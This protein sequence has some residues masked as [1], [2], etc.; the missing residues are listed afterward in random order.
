MVNGLI[1]KIIKISMSIVSVMVVLINLFPGTLLSIFGQD[2]EFID[3]AIPV[4][5]VV[6]LAMIL[7]SFSVVWLNAVTGTGNSRVTFLVELITMVLYCIYIYLVLEVWNFSIVYGWMS[8]WLYWISIFFL[9]WLYM[10]S[11]K[12]KNKVI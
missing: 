12:W 4:V 10:R 5:R 1:L 8:E 9:S 11:G 7:M 6:S 2:K 3:T